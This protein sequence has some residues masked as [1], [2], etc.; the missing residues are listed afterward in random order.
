MSVLQVARSEKMYQHLVRQ[1]SRQNEPRHLQHR[2]RGDR[3]SAEDAAQLRSWRQ[4]PRGHL[5]AR[6]RHGQKETQG[7]GKVV[8]V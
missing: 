8:D 2:S 3:A 1:L 5:R 4:C 7:G 6:R